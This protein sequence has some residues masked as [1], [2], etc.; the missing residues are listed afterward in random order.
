M[1]ATMRFVLAAILFAFGTWIVPWP[2]VPVLAALLLLLAP[3]L[4]TPGLLALAAAGAWA[5]ILGWTA[6]HAP[7]GVL[8]RELGGILHAPTAVV[9]AL[10]PAIAAALAWAGAEVARAVQVRGAKE[11]SG[12]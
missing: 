5:G 4:F 6:L 8:A 2:V 11:R 1:R 10:G 9:I 7:L 3:R 12:T